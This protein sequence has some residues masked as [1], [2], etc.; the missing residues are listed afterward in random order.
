MTKAVLVTGGNG[1]LALHLIAQLLA[2]NVPVRTSLR[3]LDKQGQVMTPLKNAGVANLDQLTF[4]A[5]DLTQDAGWPA[6]MAGID[7]VFSV[8]APVFVNGKSASDEVAEV[9]T[10]GT[11]RILK[12]AEKA[13]VRRV[14]MTANFGAVGFSNLDPRRQTTEQDWTDPDQPGLSLYER[15][16]LIA[17]QR[18]W[19]YLKDSGS[20]LEFTT[21]NAG[22]MLGTALGDHVSGSFGIVRNLLD[23][24]LKRIPDITVS[25]VDARDVAAMHILAAQTPEAAG[26]RFLAVADQPLSMPEMAALIRHERP[27]LAGRIPTRKL[28]SWLMRLAAYFNQVARE[29]NLMRTI[30]HDVSNQKAKTVLGWQPQYSAEQAVLAAADTL[31]KIGKRPV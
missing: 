27:A 17:E 1:F 11:L 2:Q 19:A 29:G 22:A 18:A 6:A 8:A 16:K 20:K 28:S 10:Q 30:S 23:G 7:T 21:I 12:A 26:Q 3:S 31:V 24:S 9:A 15:S 13:G 25:V 5:A 4:A 14:V